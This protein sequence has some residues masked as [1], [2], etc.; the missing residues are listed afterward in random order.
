M[1][2]P[3]KQI[4][5]CAHVV[6]LYICSSENGSATGQ[7]AVR[8]FVSAHVQWVQVFPDACSFLSAFL[9]VTLLL[10]RV[11]IHLG[12][13]RSTQTDG[14]WRFCVCMYYGGF[15]SSQM[16]AGLF[17]WFSAMCFCF[18]NPGGKKIREKNDKKKKGGFPVWGSARAA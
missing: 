15:R 12:G 6:G 4:I 5:C 11:Q 8:G 18:T 10:A 3:P 14:S 1:W 2:L 17:L 13:D 7:A 9:C 16:L